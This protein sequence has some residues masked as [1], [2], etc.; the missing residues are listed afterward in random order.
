MFYAMVQRTGELRCIYCG[1]VKGHNCKPTIMDILLRYPI[2]TCFVNRR[3]GGIA[4]PAQRYDVSVID[5]SLIV[6]SLDSQGHYLSDILPASIFASDWVHP[7]AG[8]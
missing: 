2:G 8:D 3:V 6:V 4:L 1:G 5:A 7:F